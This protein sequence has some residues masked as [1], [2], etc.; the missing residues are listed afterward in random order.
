MRVIDSHTEGEPT[1][2]VVEGGPELKS[3][4]LADQAIELS[5]NHQDFLNATLTEPRGFEAMVGALL[6]PANDENCETGVIF[7]TAA[8]AL[9]MCGHGTIGL[10]VTLAHM[11]C[12]GTGTHNI[13]TPVG[14]VEAELKTN[15]EVTIKNVESYRY[16]AGVKINVEGLG[17][18]TGDIA[19]GG[20]WFFLSKDMPCD[21]EFENIA[22]LLAATKAIR[23]ALIARGI[24]GK[25]G[26][27][28]DHIEFNGEG[29]DQ[30]DGRNF[31]LCPNGTYD[32][33]PCGTGTS[34]KLACLAADGTLA[35]GEEWIQES[36]VG[37]CYYASF[38]KGRK[39]GV[40]PTIT[41]R[42]F[43]TGETK[44]IRNSNDPY[45]NGMVVKFNKDKNT[46]S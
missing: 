21:L 33:S 40:I 38:Q 39:G 1:R 6:C 10:V 5:N 36:I 29:G 26:A 16:K 2:V 27:E 30:S 12:I 9:N 7:Y 32:R 44:L 34:A 14:V 22:K 17:I 18:I 13:E 43:V 15:N 45:A 35:Q 46:K 37:S 20:N 8:G 11:G 4:S 24:T 3:L 19:W 41:G 42:A 25:D 23:L 31:V 28:I